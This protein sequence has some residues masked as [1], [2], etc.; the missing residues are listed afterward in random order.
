MA[1]AGKRRPKKHRD[2]IWT[3]VP[4]GFWDTGYGARNCIPITGDT[5]IE[6]YIATV[7]D[8]DRYRYIAI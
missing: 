4:S 8:I 2:K 6:P 7:R 5:Y 3:F 1:S